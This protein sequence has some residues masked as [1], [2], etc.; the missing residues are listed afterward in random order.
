MVYYSKP[1]IKTLTLPNSSYEIKFDLI[2][3]TMVYFDILILASENNGQTN[4]DVTFYDING[5]QLQTINID[6]PAEIEGLNAN[7]GKIVLYDYIGNTRAFI[8]WTYAYYDTEQEAK[9]I[10]PFLRIKRE[11]RITT[12]IISLQ[13]SVGTTAQAISSSQTIVKKVT[14]YAPSSNS[15]NI[16]VGSSSGQN[17]PIQPGYSL[18]LENVDLSEVYVVSASG[19][20]TLYVIGGGY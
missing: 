20:Q 18:D 2:N 8:S 11:N 17:F 19:T 16:L 15:A 5:S 13:L 14:L 4:I 3:N 6:L 12:N 10:M 1:F 9:L 7:I